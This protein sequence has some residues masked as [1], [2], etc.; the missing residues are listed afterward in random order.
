MIRQTRRQRPAQSRNRPQP[1]QR[2][3]GADLTATFEVVGSTVVVTCDMIITIKALPK[4]RLMPQDVAPTGITTKTPTGFTLTFAAPPAVDSVL[5][6]PAMEPNIR[7][8]SGGYMTEGSF[9]VN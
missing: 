7:S 5:V 4:Y 1:N 2:P 6:I 9:P 8:L 3:R